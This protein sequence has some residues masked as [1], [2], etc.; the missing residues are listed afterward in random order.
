VNRKRTAAPEVDTAQRQTPPHNLEAERATLGAILLGEQTALH[1]ARQRLEGSDF[2]SEYHRR[3]WMAIVAL[4]SSSRGIDLVTL[5]EQLEGRGE[6]ELAGGPAYLSSLVDGVPKSANIEHYA[7]IVKEKSVRRAL[8]AR[9]VMMAGACANGHQLHEL[10]EEAAE[11]YRASMASDPEIRRRC[12]PTSVLMQDYAASVARGPGR[13]LRTGFDRIDKAIG[14]GVAEGEVLTVVKRPQVGGSLFGSQVIVS[15]SHQGEASVFFT[16]EMPREQA[17]ERAVG[18]RLGLTRIELEHL[19]GDG[20]RGLS[21]LQR[22]QL[23]AFGRNV[24]FVDRAKSGIADLDAS[25]LE[26]T[27]TLGRAQRLVVIDYL[28]LLSSGAKNLPLYQ[29]VSEAAVDV[30]AFAKRH[31]VAVVLIA[32]AGRDPDLARSEGA[33]RLGLDAARDSGQIEEAADFVVT[34]WR[35]ELF[36]QMGPPERRE[37]KG[38]LHGALVKNRRGPLVD[39]RL[40]LDE[41]TLQLRPWNREDEA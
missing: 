21:E 38:Q 27:A 10:Q 3:I 6:L 22:Q 34:L 33:A 32:Q 31:R 7:R 4:S 8:Q 29:R 16:L 14:G 18:Q 5:K 13:R 41:R 36:S 30:K 37:V 26:A 19:A 25:M 23:E 1:L 24:A 40:L 28:G 20:W 15:A 39:F 12:A 9:A 2:F 35:P 11:L 17:F